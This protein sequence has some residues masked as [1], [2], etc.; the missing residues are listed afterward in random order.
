MYLVFD[1]GGTKTRI[2]ISKDGKTIE[3]TTFLQTNTNDYKAALKEF[4]TAALSLT[5]G[6]LIKAVAGG[7]PGTLDREHGSIIAAPNL[8]DWAGKAFQQDLERLFHAPA[9]IEN[10]TAIIG[11]GEA[12]FGAGANKRI[13]VYMTISTGV[14]GCRIVDNTVDTNAFGF[15]PGHQIVDINGPKCACGVKGH[16]EAIIGGASLQKQYK[17]SPENITD[18]KVWNMVARCLAVGINNIMMFWS[19]D[20]IVLGG[21][22]M[23]TLDLETVRSYTKEIVTIYPDIP[24]IVLP[25]LGEQGGLLGGLS[26]IASK[27]R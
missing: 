22:L 3:K 5:E 17:K 18:P 4:H 15:E 13:V 2:G 19:P 26:L 11:L 16:L 7:L 12:A 20:C 14:G 1:I 8:P 27:K 24:E 10:D 25:T 21:S 6:A 23:K 9:A